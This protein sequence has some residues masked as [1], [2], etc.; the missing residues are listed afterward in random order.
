[1]RAEL[2]SLLERFSTERETLPPLLVSHADAYEAVAQIFGEPLCDTPESLVG[3]CLPD[4]FVLIKERDGEGALGVKDVA[5]FIERSSYSPQ[6]PVQVFV[7]EDID[8]VSEEA[9]NALLKV[10]EEPPER[11]LILVPIG[12]PNTLL[13]TLRS[14]MILVSF[15]R[16]EQK[17]DPEWGS[18]LRAYVASGRMLET[19]KKWNALGKPSKDDVKVILRTLVDVLASSGNMYP[20]TT[21]RI[22]HA[23]DLLENVQ[24]SP[25]TVGDSV[26]FALFEETT[27]LLRVR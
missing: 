3:L 4:L 26:L 10:L 13:P 24:I 14:R 15:D 7:L 25:R 17:T 23:F 21:E 1:M 9:A 5:K 20:L 11:T 19:V 27:H 12:S 2:E 16:D 22:E 6:G 8:L 18:V